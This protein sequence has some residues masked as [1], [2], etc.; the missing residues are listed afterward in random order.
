MESPVEK[1]LQLE[2]VIFAVIRHWLTPFVR[3]SRYAFG[4]TMP[5][6][7]CTGYAETRQPFCRGWGGTN[8]SPPPGRR[9]CRETRGGCSLW[10]LSRFGPVDKLRIAATHMVYW[11]RKSKGGDVG[12]M[13][14]RGWSTAEDVMCNVGVAHAA[15]TF[16]QTVGQPDGLQLIYQRVESLYF[17]Q[18]PAVHRPCGRCQ[19]AA[20]RLPVRHR[21]ERRLEQE[22]RVNIAYRWF[23]GIDL[24]EPVPDHLPSPNC[25]A[26]IQWRCAVRGTVRRSG[27]EVH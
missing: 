15:G 16:P 5:P 18:R 6:F 12:M 27:S 3:A 8:R 21:P 4:H 22:V 2:V 1:A 10:G 14:R 24:D 20:A 25:A 11:R 26:A 19:D 7:L 13:T 17:T 9:P 23:L